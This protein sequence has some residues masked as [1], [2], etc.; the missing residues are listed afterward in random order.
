MNSHLSI[1]TPPGSFSSPS[2]SMT[3]Y[4]E[5]Y[6]LS[7]T[8]SISTVASYCNDINRSTPRK[9]SYSSDDEYEDLNNNNNDNNVRAKK[10]RVQQKYIDE[11]LLLKVS[12][13]LNPL[14][15]FIAK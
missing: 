4:S 5:D 9:V 14:R 8:N 10:M 13:C 12:Q 7:P 1:M 3:P 6:R 2:L 11:F 15:L